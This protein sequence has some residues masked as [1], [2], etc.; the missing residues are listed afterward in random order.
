MRVLVVDNETPHGVS[1]AERLA[2]QGHEAAVVA[3]GQ[4]ALAHIERGVIDLVLADN[5]VPDFGGLELLR[6]IKS[7]PRPRTE[8]VLMSSNGS[9]RA[10]VEAVKS[11]AFDFVAKPLT[12]PEIAALVTRMEQQA[13]RGDRWK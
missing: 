5:K 13:Q 12:S 10:A 3:D 11:G 9:I 8:V 1:L 4:Q 7:G 6:R 2:E